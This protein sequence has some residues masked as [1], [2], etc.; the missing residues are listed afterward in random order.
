MRYAILCVLVVLALPLGVPGSA[1]ADTVVST[2]YYPWFG[3]DSHDGDYAH[4]AQG[5]HSPP[6][7]IASHYYPAVGVYSS[8][9]A[10]VLSEQMVDVAKAGISEIAVSWWG[11]GSAED[12][13]LP[14]VIAAA[15]Q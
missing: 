11:K 6:N 5:G 9:S 10:A 2:F 3:T 1:F 8:S 12:Q 7:D 15:G 4:W 13:R 14:D